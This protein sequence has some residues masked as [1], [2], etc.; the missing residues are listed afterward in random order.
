MNPSCLH[1][2]SP[3]PFIHQAFRGYWIY[4]RLDALIG[5][6]TMQQWLSHSLCAQASHRPENTWLDEQTT[7]RSITSWTYGSSG[8]FICLEGWR[9]REGS[10]EKVVCELNLK[11]QAVLNQPRDGENILGGEEQVSAETWGVR[12]AWNTRTANVVAGDPGI[13]RQGWVCSSR[14]APRLIGWTSGDGKLQKMIN[15][16]MA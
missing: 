5:V 3:S 14:Q 4:D 12:G 15:K 7:I 2:A 16:R 9:A 6:R 13:D 10:R 8:P 11:G 1:F